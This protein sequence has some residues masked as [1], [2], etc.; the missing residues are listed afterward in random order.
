MNIDKTLRKIEDLI[1]KFWFMQFEFPEKYKKLYKTDGGKFKWCNEL[2]INIPEKWNVSKV[3]EY[4]SIERG[5]SYSNKN[6]DNEGIPMVNLNSFNPDS[7]YKVNGLKRFIGKYNK[8]KVVKSYDL[9]MC[10]TQQTAIDLIKNT[11]VIGKTFLMPDIYDGDIIISMDVVNIKTNCKLS[12]YYINSLF[13]QEYFHK[14]ITGFANGTKIKHLDINGVLEFPCII[15]TEDILK[16]YDEIAI[17]CEEKRS[18]LIRENI[19][20]NKLR[21]YLMPMLINS[22]V[23]FKELSDVIKI[24]NISSNVKEKV[25]S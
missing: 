18:N 12:K 17:E 19:E 7:S 20:L 16:K 23:K 9:L 3:G 15:P 2:G 22:Q 24:K 1:F 6:L 25:K 5:I 13:R 8:E 11:D 4:V 21:E 10:V 14:Y